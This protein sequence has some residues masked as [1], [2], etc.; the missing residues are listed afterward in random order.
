MK[1]VIAIMITI[2]IGIGML[3][4]CGN[5]KKP[6]NQSDPEPQPQTQPNQGGLQFED[7]TGMDNNGDT[8]EDVDIDD[9]LEPE[10]DTED[11]EDT[12]NTEENNEDTQGEEIVEPVRFPD[13]PR[14]MWCY[15]AIYTMTQGGLVSGYGNGT[16]GPS[17]TITIGQFAQIMARAKGYEI[18][19]GETGWWAELA[20]QNCLDNEII[21]DRG[22]VTQETYDVPITRE[23]AVAALQLA[24][25]K[26]N[27][28]KNMFSLSDIPDY[29]DIDEKYKDLIVEAYNSG[30]TSGV[31]ETRAFLPKKNLTRAEVCQ[32]F[33]NIGWTTAGIGAD[34]EE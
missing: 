2:L 13:V 12:E 26:E 1:R 23:E 9:F 17:D 8:S 3:S 25:E 31:D 16:F 5:S 18:G 19:A 15:N 27:T 32:L 7:E 21:T 22:P 28:D 11:T 4:G 30:I 34:T 33:Y 24:T 10:D 29:E 20:V 6:I 14:S